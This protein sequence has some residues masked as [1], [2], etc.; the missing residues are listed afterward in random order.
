MMV[1]LPGALWRQATALA[2]LRKLGLCSSSCSYVPLRDH[3]AISH[4]N[5]GVATL[6][7][8]EPAGNQQNGEVAA[9]VFDGIHQESILGILPGKLGGKH[10]NGLRQ[11]DKFNILTAFQGQASHFSVEPR[12]EAPSV[13]G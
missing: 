4:L 3:P 9:K 1:K 6:H 2:L 11:R 5:D 12:R 10:F 8:G 7:G 13:A